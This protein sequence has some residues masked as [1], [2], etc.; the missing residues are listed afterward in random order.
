VG[1]LAFGTSVLPGDDRIAL[2]L[3]CGLFMGA[4]EDRFPCACH[5]VELFYNGRSGEYSGVH[6]FSLSIER[7]KA[8]LRRGHLFGSL[9]CLR[10]FDPGMESP[11][12]RLSHLPLKVPSEYRP[13]SICP[14]RRA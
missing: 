12:W 14:C 4:A 2:A 9:C 3:C 5:S 11:G 13:S 8:C 10:A 7:K 6:N 1:R